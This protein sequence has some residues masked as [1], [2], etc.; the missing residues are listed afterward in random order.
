MLDVTPTVKQ[1]LE[2]RPGHEKLRIVLLLGA[3]DAHLAKLVT[4]LPWVEQLVVG[5][6]AVITSL[7]PAARLTKLTMLHVN[8]NAVT[9]LAPL[10][11]HPRLDTS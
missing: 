4:M 11:K 5:E 10:A 2:A 3:T 1:D 9:T 7:A 8:S 6:P